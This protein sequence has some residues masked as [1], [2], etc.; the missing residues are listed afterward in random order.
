MTRR[1]LLIQGHPDP[2]Q[3]R[4]CRGLADHYAN[5]A[6][7]AGHEL[8]VIDI[9]TLDF[10]LIR[11]SPQFYA[12]DI[13]EPIA[14]AQLDVEWCEH[15]V[16]VF[17][18]WLGAMPAL[19]KGFFEQLFR[20]AFTMPPGGV[21]GRDAPRLRGRSAHM[22][23]TM[24]MPALIYRLVFG[25]HGLHAFR[26]NLKL[27]AGIGPMRMTM[28]GNTERQPKHIDRFLRKMTEAGRRAG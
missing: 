9:A 19:L 1:I 22:V 28:I 24:G 21:V 14:A 3:T 20:P 11:S 12:A 8:R 15:I 4:L 6:R 2:L 10:P 17:P 27:F 13:P 23:V 18:V 5:G 25:A 7:A 26:R 16:L